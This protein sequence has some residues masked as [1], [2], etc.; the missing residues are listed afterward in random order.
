MST[1][2]EVLMQHEGP[3][4]ADGMGHFQCFCGYDCA[5]GKW[6]G[7]NWATKNWAEHVADVIRQANVDLT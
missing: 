5:D 2:A 3:I 6:S 1:L 4:F 7:C